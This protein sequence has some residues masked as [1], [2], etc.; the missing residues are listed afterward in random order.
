MDWHFPKSDP[1][2]EANIASYSRT[3]IEGERTISGLEIFVR[4]ALQNSLD[5]AKDTTRKVTVQFRLRTLL[6]TGLA[7]FF[8]ALN[9]PDLKKFAAAASRASSQRMDRYRFPEPAEL[10]N[11]VVRVLEI[12]ETNTIGLIGPD[13]GCRG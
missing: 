5:A 12:N 6:G 2:G 3:I 4:E 13:I 11:G 7:T 1:A 10:E 8:Q 9:W